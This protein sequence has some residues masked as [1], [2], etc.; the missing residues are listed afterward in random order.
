MKITHKINKD[1]E[2]TIDRGRGSNTSTWKLT[3]P[4]VDEV[5]SYLTP[6]DPKSVLAMEYIKSTLK[7]DIA[8]ALRIAKYIESIKMS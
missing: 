2:F 3:K 5:R 7:C 8:D 1:I 4:Q 6:K